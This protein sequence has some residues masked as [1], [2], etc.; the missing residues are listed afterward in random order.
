M[1]LLKGVL[2]DNVFIDF[3]AEIEYGSDQAY[4]NQPTRFA[5][6][7]FQLIS[8]FLLA[9][10]FDRIRVGKGLQPMHPIDGY[11]WEDC[12]RTGWYD[13]F[14]G[15]NDLSPTR[16]DSCIEAMVCNSTC[17]DDGERYSV[18]LTGEEQRAMFERLDEQC[19]SHLG[20]GCIELLAEARRRMEGD[21]T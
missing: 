10:L 5:T 20:K 1:T 3:G 9:G 11:G 13:I 18:E 2:K 21:V 16:T 12:D 8:S 15:I 4:K 19:R 14:V 17:P 7:T 6:V